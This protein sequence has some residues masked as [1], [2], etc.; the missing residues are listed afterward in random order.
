MKAWTGYAGASLALV[1]V[2]A[3]VAG[4][5]LPESYGRAVWVS[6]A[7]AYLLQ[8]IAFAALVAVRRDRTLIMAGWAGGIGLR[9]LALVVMAWWAAE[10]AALPREPLLV[11][12]VAYLF[13]LL[14]LEPV[15]LKRGM[16]AS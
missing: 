14:L 1:V 7:V 8:L 13:L 15:F 16:N 3:A 11:S 2:V 5:V 4:A 9:V 12:L 6:A 10:S